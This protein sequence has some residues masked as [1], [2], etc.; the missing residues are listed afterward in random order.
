MPRWQD[1]NHL[2]L[3]SDQVIAGILPIRPDKLGGAA[4][5]G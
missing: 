4:V 2:G 3:S 1:L 5:Q